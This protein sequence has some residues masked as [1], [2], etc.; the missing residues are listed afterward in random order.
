MESKMS[1]LCALGSEVATVSDLR[2]SPAETLF[3]ARCRLMGS[4]SGEIEPRTIPWAMLLL[5]AAAA[6]VPILLWAL[7]FHGVETPIAYRVESSR[8]EPAASFVETDDDKATIRFDEGSI[9]TVSP[10]TGMRVLQTQPRGVALSVERGRIHCNVV[11]KQATEWTV[12]A[13]PFDIRVTG[14]QF[15]TEWQPRPGRFEL[16][17][18][19][20]SVEVSGPEIAGKQHVAAGER[21]VVDVGWGTKTLAGRGT[22]LAAGLEHLEAIGVPDAGSVVASAAASTGESKTESKPLNAPSWESLA[23]T[24]RY[25]EAVSEIRATGIEAVIEGS[26]GAK[27]RLLA[28]TLRMA[29]A[30][31][32]AKNALLVLRERHGVRT[33]TAFLLGKIAADHSNVPAEALKWFEAYLREEPEGALREQALGRCLELEHHVGGQRR[34]LE[35]AQ[36]Y[37]ASYPKGVYAPLAESVLAK[38]SIGEVQ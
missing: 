33:E 22:L 5:G 7:L 6:A 34:T 30:P 13:G 10:E 8:V 31:E 17:L 12:R 38:D 26:N 21:L 1:R 35:R 25:R 4:S 9:I 29:G 3:Q 36:R 27:L 28:D 14:T 32:L 15:E 18:I 24:G 23:A 16:T 11:H 2:A 19:E 20:G 37:L